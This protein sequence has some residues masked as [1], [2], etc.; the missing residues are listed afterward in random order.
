VNDDRARRLRA[1]Y[2]DST[3]RGEPWIATKEHFRTLF[4][5]DPA[6]GEAEQMVVNAWTEE[7]ELRGERYDVGA[8]CWRD[9]EGKRVD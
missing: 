1:F 4:G 3:R 2:R 5:R 6:R 8:Q 7:R 9:R